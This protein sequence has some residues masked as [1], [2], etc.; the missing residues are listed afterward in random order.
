MTL[1][2]MVRSMMSYS[3]L[4][5]SF[6]G[7]ALNTAIHLLNLVPSKS[8][9]KTPMELWSRHKPSMKYLHIWGCLAHVLKG[10]PDK[11]EPKSEVEAAKEAIWLTKFLSNLHVVRIEQVPITLFCDN[12]GVVA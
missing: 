11:L 3:T 7:Y 2:E 9:P 8:V 6:W 5:I 4:L 10:K 12:S 1:L